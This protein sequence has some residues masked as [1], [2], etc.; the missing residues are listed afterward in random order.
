MRVQSLMTDCT[1]RSSADK[2]Q[3]NRY[4][5]PTDN[6]R[7][8]SPEGLLLLSNRA[9]RV[10]IN[11]DITTLQELDYGT[12]FFRLLGKNR[13]VASNVFLRQPNESECD[14]PPMD[15]HSLGI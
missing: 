2:T 8:P 10:E 13:F 3:T 4:L 1:Y 9:K 5:V 11:S 7:R 14:R 15:G 6:Q 12:L